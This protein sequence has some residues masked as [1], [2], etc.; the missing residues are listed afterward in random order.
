M[1]LFRQFSEIE[2]TVV[3]LFT[4][5]VPPQYAAA[6]PYYTSLVNA[7]HQAF[8]KDNPY[9]CD[10]DTTPS[11]DIITLIKFELNFVNSVEASH[12]L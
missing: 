1:V 9:P 2:S 7:I 10:K 12:F 4:P 11:T 3:S 6:Y 5:H 8:E